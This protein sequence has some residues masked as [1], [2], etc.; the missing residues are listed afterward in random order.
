MPTTKHK[1]ISAKADGVDA[2]E[3]R[4][5][6]WN[7]DHDLKTLGASVYLGQS[8]AGAGPVL[9]LPIQAQ[10]GDDYTIMTK[11]AVEAAIAN[12]F[13]NYHPYVT[14]DI[15]ASLL[16]SKSGWAKCNG[17]GLFLGNG[18]TNHDLFV[19]LWGINGGSWPVTPSRGASA[20]ADWLASKVINVPDIRGSTLGMIDETGIVHSLL[21]PTTFGLRVGVE[22]LAL[23]APNLPAHTHAVPGTV[24]AGATMMTGAG[25]RSDVLA[26]DG[27]SGST[28]SGTAINLTQPTVGVNFFIKM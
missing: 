21:T 1:K 15:I 16:S 23:T 13:A 28:G 26:N 7:A 6:D 8:A 14:G 17:T 3:V 5:S 2:T 12:A 25:A 22:K 24:P 11:A 4:P 9:E 18:Q 27:T 20:E 10:A 19:M